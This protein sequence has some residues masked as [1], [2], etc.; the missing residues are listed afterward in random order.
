MSNPTGE[1]L[2]ALSLPQV[3]AVAVA[4][5]RLKLEEGFKPYP[6][7]DTKGHLTQGYGCNLAAGWSPGLARCVLDYQLNEV[8]L[9]V[10]AFW[11]FTDLDAARA[12]VVLD[13]GFNDG[14][15]SLLHFPKMLAAIGAKNWQAAHDELLDSDA[16]R[17]LPS[18]YQPLARILLTGELT[19]TQS[20]STELPTSS[21][22][23][24][25]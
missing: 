22:P 15:T 14:V 9:S 12:S 7:K 23:S 16:A 17:E 20:P 3:Q 11:W 13:V 8:L 6:Y 2:A 5:T 21:A 4:A 24:S 18:R 1:A 25:R 19:S 10:K